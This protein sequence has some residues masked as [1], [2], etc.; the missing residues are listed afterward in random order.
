MLHPRFALGSPIEVSLRLDHAGYPGMAL[1]PLS[2]LSKELWPV[3]RGGAGA[4][5]ARR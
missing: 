5:V 2:Q 4:R 1:I 3:G